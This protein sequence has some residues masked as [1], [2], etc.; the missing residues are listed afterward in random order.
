MKTVAVVRDLFF[1]AKIAE[2]ARLLEAEM[3]FAD[4]FAKVQKAGQIFVDLEEFAAD[5]IKMLRQ[6]NPGARVIGY[7]SHVNVEKRKAAEQAGF[8][9]VL[10][11]SEFSKMLPDLLAKHHMTK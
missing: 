7:L 4:S 6:N 9:L 11:R 2:T 5:G 8:D 1:Q 3:E 10:A